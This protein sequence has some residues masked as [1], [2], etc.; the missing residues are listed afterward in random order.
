MKVKYSLW[1]TCIL[2]E[3]DREV[4]F[5]FLIPKSFNRYKEAAAAEGLYYVK[6]RMF[7][8]GRVVF[9][10]F[11]KP[12]ALVDTIW[13]EE[14]WKYRCTIMKQSGVVKTLA[15]VF[16]EKKLN[17]MEELSQF[18]CAEITDYEPYADK[19]QDMYKKYLT[20]YAIEDVFQYAAQCV[21]YC[22]KPICVEEK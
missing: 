12:D 20:K 8:N 22:V 7:E 17:S 19:F 13:W 18:P 6:P 4:D 21:A 2:D 15:E 10:V 14:Y 3:L 16:P 1:L 11:Q 5:D 9:E